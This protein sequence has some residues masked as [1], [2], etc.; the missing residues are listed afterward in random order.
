[1]GRRRARTKKPSIKAKVRKEEGHMMD[2]MI[3]RELHREKEEEWLRRAQIA[4][5]LQALRSA[6]DFVPSKLSR[7]PFFPW[8][9]LPTRWQRSGY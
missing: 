2:W 4:S 7:R 5:A 6:T 1:M 3:V 9:K 8:K